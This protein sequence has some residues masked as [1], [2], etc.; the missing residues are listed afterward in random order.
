MSMRAESRARMARAGAL[1]HVQRVQAADVGERGGALERVGVERGDA[2]GTPRAGRSG[3]SSR[4]P[5]PTAAP[6]A[7]SA[8]CSSPASPAAGPGELA[9]LQRQLD[10]GLE[11][12]RARIGRLLRAAPL[13]GEAEHLDLLGEVG[14]V[15]RERLGQQDAAAYACSSR[16]SSFRSSTSASVSGGRSSRPRPLRVRVRAPVGDGRPAE[17][18]VQEREELGE[19]LGRADVG[20]LL[21]QVP[22][23]LVERT[24][25]ERVVRRDEA[26]DHPGLEVRRDVA[27]LGQASSS[28]SVDV[29]AGSQGGTNPA[30]GRPERRGGGSTK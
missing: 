10:A 25:G 19:A 27:A 22:L 18:E 23:R 12:E 1:D 21:V 17:L 4:E 16:S 3:G 6:R 5:P 30:P 2:R 28:V 11:W 26:A 7:G 14:A 24:L 15:P 8:P 29:G 9:F 13:L 20:E